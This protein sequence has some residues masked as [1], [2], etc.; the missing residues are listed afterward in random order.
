MKTLAAGLATELAKRGRSLSRIH[1]LDVQTGDG[2]NFFWSDFE[3][4]FPSV[5]T[6]TNQVYKPWIKQAPSI[7]HFRSLQADGGDFSLQNLSG[8]LIDRE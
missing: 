1:L 4:V 2:Q 6:G 5:L 8:N 7:K 3:G